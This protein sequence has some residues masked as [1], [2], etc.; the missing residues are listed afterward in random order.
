[1]ASWQP[2]EFNINN[3]N[4][5]S[6][7]EDGDGLGAETIN[8]VVEASAF[9]Q[10]LGKNQPQY[11]ENGGNPSVS[12]QNDRFVFSN[13]KGDNG[14][15]GANGATFT[16]SVSSDG[17]LSWTNDKGLTN[18]IA[19]NIKG[20]KGDKGDGVPSNMSQNDNNTII[21]DGSKVNGNWNATFILQQGGKQ[22]PICTQYTNHTGAKAEI[23]A[24]ANSA[25]FKFVNGST[26]PQS[27][28]EI[29]ADTINFSKP[30][31]VDKKPISGG[32]KTMLLLQGSNGYGNYEISFKIPSE[33]ANKVTINY[34]IQYN[35]YRYAT[36]YA[37][38]NIVIFD[39]SPLTGQ[40]LRLLT[41]EYDG[42]GMGIYL[43]VPIYWS[44]SDDVLVLDFYQ[45]GNNAFGYGVGGETTSILFTIE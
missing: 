28:M 9:V 20:D 30:I 31:T 26:D 44:T 4:G 5:G 33:N 3:I 27:Y 45:A 34:T 37:N 18:P 13:L 21:V 25:K 39:G 15:D 38:Q 16:P 11:T 43:D 8:A 29:F 1:M 23:V 17:T 12:I 7:Y 2:K 14:K 24:T 36:E 41:N 32:G 19:I 10:N 40:K 42:S 6:R 35:S 22:R